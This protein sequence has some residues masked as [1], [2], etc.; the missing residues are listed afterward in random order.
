MAII[1]H[2]WTGAA[3]LDRPLPLLEAALGIPKAECHDE[4]KFP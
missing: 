2:W 1:G 4:G 3:S